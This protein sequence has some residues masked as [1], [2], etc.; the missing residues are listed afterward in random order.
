[1]GVPVNESAVRELK[2]LAEK[3]T[4]GEWQED[5]LLWAG[6]VVEADASA[7]GGEDWITF[8]SRR[9]EADRALFVAAVNLVVPLAED[10]LRLKRIEEAAQEVLAARAAYDA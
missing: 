3:A 5:G 7:N 1:M 9:A 6:D 10:W 8:K 2:E 4:Q